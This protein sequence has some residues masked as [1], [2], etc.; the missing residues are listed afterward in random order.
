MSLQRMCL[1][2]HEFH[3]HEKTETEIAELSDV[4][5]TT[6]LHIKVLQYV[7]TNKSL[8]Q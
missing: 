7:I 5:T 2:F 8:L 3:T 6:H 1:E 4:N